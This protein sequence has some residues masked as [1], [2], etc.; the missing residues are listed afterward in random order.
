LRALPAEVAQA[1]AALAS[2]ERQAAASSDALSRE[3]S[4][5]TRLER[6][7]A[8][9]RQKLARF[10]TQLD[11]VKTPAQAAAIEHEIQFASDE[12]SRLE[13]EEL[14]SLERTETEESA[15]ATARAEVERLAAALDKTRACAAQRLQEL[16]AELAVLNV[17]R[18]TLRQA[19]EPEWLT[20]FDR[21]AGSRGTGLARAENQQCNGCR[22][23][24]RPQT[25]NQLREG[26]LLSCDSCG[27]LLYWDPAFAPAPKSPQAA[28]PEPK[29]RARKSQAGD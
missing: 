5:R 6:E 24:V 11:A 28:G 1:E 21:L 12:A 18:E 16:N 19:I 8:A 10:R 14:L 26:E 23:G 2:A 17:E 3:E 29:S 27:R 15:L 20:R 22:M 9:F 4:L 25:W 13:D 7:I